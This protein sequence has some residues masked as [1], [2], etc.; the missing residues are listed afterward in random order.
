MQQFQVPQFIDVE[1]KL[2]GPFTIKQFVYVAGGGGLIYLY[3]ELLP[4]AVAFILALPTGALALALA[5]RKV[6]GQPFVKIIQAFFTHHISSKMYLWQKDYNQTQVSDT[7]I[8][9]AIQ[10][11]IT[12]AEQIKPRGNLRNLSWSLNVLDDSEETNVDEI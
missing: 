11:E 8:K 6:N 3:L 5:F 12:P 1:D 7:Q 9:Q 2:F 10:T 4:N